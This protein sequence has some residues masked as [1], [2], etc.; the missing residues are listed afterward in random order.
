[1]TLPGA[2]RLDRALAQLA[3][4]ATDRDAHLAGAELVLARARPLSRSRRVRATGKA[5]ATAKAGKAQFG[6]PQVRWAVP[7]HFGHGAPGRPRAQGGYMLANPYLFKGSDLARDSVI[8]L[9]LNR[10]MRAIKA[11]GLG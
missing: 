3:V 9:Y 2:E 7:S 6:S 8:D 1:M 11:S 10:T 5:T 4:D